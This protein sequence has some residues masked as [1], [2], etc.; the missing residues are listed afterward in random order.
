[1][2][3][4]RTQFV[5]VLRP[6]EDLRPAAIVTVEDSSKKGEGH[7]TRSMTGSC[8]R[9]QDRKRRGWEQDT[10]TAEGCD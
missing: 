5:L 9:I 3:V 8:K 6:V 10:D 7:Y 2:P 1:V 4:R